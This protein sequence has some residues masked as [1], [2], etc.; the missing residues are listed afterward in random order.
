MHGMDPL[1]ALGLAAAVV[2]FVDFGFR[3]VNDARQRYKSVS[4]GRILELVHLSTIAADLGQLSTNIRD[5]SSRLGRPV[6]F[7]TGSSENV[8]REICQQ[9]IDINAEMEKVI[10]LWE[11]T[12]SETSKEAV[13]AF[14]FMG[15]RR[16]DKF[17]GRLEK[18]PMFSDLLSDSRI[19][20]W[21]AQ[22]ES[23]RSRMVTTSVAA[24]W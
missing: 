13:F 23:I 14:G 1:S 17:G 9:C 22:L 8:L 4:S 3:L 16:K 19:A 15:R 5:E 20:L 2:Q 6:G 21:K 11:S 10:K 18:D 7:K 12:Q 24:L